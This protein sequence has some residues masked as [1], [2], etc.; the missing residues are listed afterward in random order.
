MCIKLIYYQ[1]DDVT[2]MAT[3]IIL[4]REKCCNNSNN[5]IN[6]NTNTKYIRKNEQRPV[7]IYK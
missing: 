6:N 7:L 4:N 3:R 5:R 2:N 1:T